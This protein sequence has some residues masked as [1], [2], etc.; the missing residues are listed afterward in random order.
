[1]MTI[2]IRLNTKLY[3]WPTHIILLCCFVFVFFTN[4]TF[5]KVWILIGLMFYLLLMIW[6]ISQ[7]G[8][9]SFKGKKL[10]YLVGFNICL[11]FSILSILLMYLLH[12]DY[13]EDNSE[14]LSDE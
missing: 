5:L 3:N 9:L 14:S 12:K 2:L 10:G 6:R 1:M 8:F 11:L 4:L 13:R 7:D